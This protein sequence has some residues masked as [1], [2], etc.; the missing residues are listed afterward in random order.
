MRWSFIMEAGNSVLKTL[1]WV[2]IGQS[3]IVGLLLLMGYRWGAL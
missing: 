1:I 2:T 3:P